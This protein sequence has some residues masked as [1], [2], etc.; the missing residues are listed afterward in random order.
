VDTDLLA[1][2]NGL[3]YYKL[4]PPKSLGFE[5]SDLNILPIIAHTP[6]TV[7]DLLAT[8]TE[9]VAVQISETLASFPP[10]TLLITGGGAKNGYLIERLRVHTHH[11]ITIPS[12]III[13]FKEALIFAFLGV[14]RM[15]GEA[16][17]LSSVTGATQDAIGGAVYL[18]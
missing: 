4:S 15:R 9:H 3:D 5:W 14:L 17:C 8:Y 18:P 2:L 1:T 16:N 13:D 6:L 12:S 7:P 11:A 10:S